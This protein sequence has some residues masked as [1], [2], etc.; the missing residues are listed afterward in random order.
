M[1]E[2]VSAFFPLSETATKAQCKCVHSFVYFSIALEGRSQ[3]LC[4][5]F[6]SG[7]FS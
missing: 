1:T 6:H 2:N 5:S 4:E 7:F 3:N